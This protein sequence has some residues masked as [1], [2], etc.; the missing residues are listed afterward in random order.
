V[1]WDWL[2]QGVSPYH[3]FLY[4]FKTYAYVIWLVVSAALKNM[5]QLRLLFPIYGK[6]KNVPTH[7]PV[8][9]TPLEVVVQQY[10]ELTRKQ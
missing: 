1:K 5:S 4:F 6:I 8:I 2:H 10:H 7:Q 3:S 9:Y